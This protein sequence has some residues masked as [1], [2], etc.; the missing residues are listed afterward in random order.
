MSTSE[1]II[2]ILIVDDSR[3]TRDL[4][5]FIAESDPQ[6]N[7]M[8]YANDG[9]E[10]IKFLENNK[11]DVIIMD[12]VMPKMNGFEATQHIMKTHPTPII[13]ISGIYNREEVAKG[14]E[15]IKA[16]ALAIIEKPKGVGDSQHIE[17]AR[18]VIQTIK[19]ISEIKLHIGKNVFEAP[20][21]VSESIARVAA[22]PPPSPYAKRKINAVAIG[23]SIG[24]PQALCTILSKLPASFP[25]PIFV[26]Q[27]ISA[28]FIQGLVNWLSESTTLKVSL[29]KHGEKASP[30]NVYVAPDNVNMEIL[31]GNII[32]L[33]QKHEAEENSPSISK[34]FNS[35]AKT[36]GNASIA[37]LLT[38]LGKDGARELLKLKELGAVTITQDEET[39][40]VFELPQEAIKLG[41]ATN[42]ESVQQIPS[43]LSQLAGV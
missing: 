21:K 24:G 38:G 26:V 2:N 18:F 11:P 14:F 8:G 41:A 9:E 10:A 42:I 5:T 29:A 22:T 13:I 19:V 34:L 25:A 7:I 6:L 36:H 28:G 4:L 23:A 40:V 15:A 27:Q 37:V 12:I 39:C 17:M 30:G 3:V 35:I 32:N 20:S 16:G 1:R 31:E 33:T 43:T